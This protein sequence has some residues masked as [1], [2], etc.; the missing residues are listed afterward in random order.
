[1]DLFWCVERGYVLRAGLDSAKKVSFCENHTH[2]FELILT[3]LASHRTSHKAEK[4]VQNSICGDYRFCFAKITQLFELILTIPAHRT[5]HKAAQ[6]VQNCLSGG[7]FKNLLRFFGFPAM[8]MHLA[9]AAFTH[10]NACLFQRLRTKPR[11][12]SFTHKIASF[13]VY[14]QNRDL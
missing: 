4:Y 11:A 6:Y 9:F 5:S 14:A 10:K 1:M 12:F 8:Q 13:F 7:F 3:I 2:L